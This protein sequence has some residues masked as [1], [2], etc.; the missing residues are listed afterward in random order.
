MA[1]DTSVSDWERRLVQ[2]VRCSSLYWGEHVRLSRLNWLVLC[3]HCIF[4]V[5]K[6]LLLLDKVASS[7]FLRSLCETTRCDKSSVFLTSSLYGGLSI[8][9]EHWSSTCNRLR[10]LI[11][12]A[13]EVPVFNCAVWHDHFSMAVLNTMTPL[14]DVASTV[15]PS[16]LSLPMPLILSVFSFVDVSTGPRES[17]KPMLSVVLILSF[18]LIYSFM[19]PCRSTSP[20]AFAML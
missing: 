8:W 12:V 20:T 3:L 11:D 14:A 10:S 7:S 17:T 13:V 6:Y 5:F 18:I 16:H 4:E 1:N 19:L 15:G 2:L 9:G